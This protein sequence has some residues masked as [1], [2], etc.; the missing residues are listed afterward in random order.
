MSVLGHVWVSAAPELR[1]PPGNPGT[2]VSELVSAEQRLLVSGL[3]TR[4]FLPVPVSWYFTACSLWT[5]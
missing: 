3:C 2:G 1:W 4:V 5:S